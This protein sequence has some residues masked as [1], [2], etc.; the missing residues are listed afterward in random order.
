V[1]KVL[2]GVMGA[3]SLLAV[4]ACGSESGGSVA[5]ETV[6][7]QA[8]APATATPTQEI[9]AA[10]VAGTAAPAP[11]A[12]RVPMPDVTCMNLQDAQNAIQVAGVFF[13]RSD[14]ATGQG[15]AQIVDRNWVVVS[16]TPA[17]GALIG[18][19]DA[20]LSAVKIGERGDCS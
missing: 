9:P 3:V 13:S 4:S 10:P 12:V 14:D 19:G 16:Q 5:T 8:S 18:E 7:V 1:K 11:T 17:P 15:R 6:T 2:V 20:V